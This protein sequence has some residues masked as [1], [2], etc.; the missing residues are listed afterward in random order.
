MVSCVNDCL[1]TRASKDEAIRER[2]EQ[3]LTTTEKMVRLNAAFAAMA[4][5]LTEN[6]LAEMTAAMSEVKSMADLLPL[7]EAIRALA[8]RHGV[9]EIYAF[10]MFAGDLRRQGDLCFLVRWE[11]KAAW[12]QQIGLYKDVRAL[13]GLRPYLFD[14]QAFE[15]ADREGILEKAI[16]L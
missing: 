14:Y 2:P 11:S 7:R 12:Q 13:L 9:A 15:Q 4:D 8:R 5:G 16:S 6:E 1:L 10:E 3:G